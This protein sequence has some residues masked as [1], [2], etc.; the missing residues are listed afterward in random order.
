MPYEPRAFDE[1]LTSYSE[2]STLAKC[3]EL[4]V[5]SYLEPEEYPPT[6]K[7]QYGSLLH[8]MAADWWETGEL[9][10]AYS[11]HDEL[12]EGDR[13]HDLLGEKEYEDSD[14][15]MA[16]YAKV[17]GPVQSE[18]RVVATELELAAEI[19]GTGVTLTSH[20][21]GVIEHNGVLW[22][23]ERKTMD[24]WRGLDLVPVSPQVTLYEWSLREN[25]Y[26]IA[27]TL[28]DAIKR[29]RWTRDEA[30]HPPEDSV[31]WQWITRTDQQIEGAL[32]WAR[33][34]LARR[35]NLTLDGYVPIKNIGPMSCGGCWRAED[36]WA[37]LSFPKVV[38]LVEVGE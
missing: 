33:S 22:S 31:N 2:L 35:T 19:P 37:D 27:G 9:R 26:A 4:W 21:D 29:Y 5:G 13:G 36:C 28:F 7:M 14:W 20:I 25:G 1:K 38:D 30:K 6:L 10:P 8:L 12:V 18:S 17:A 34:L 16:R 3:E 11:F 15:I 32:Q 24:N 23:V